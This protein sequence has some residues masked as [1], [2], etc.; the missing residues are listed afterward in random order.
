MT[1]IVCEGYDSCGANSADFIV[2]A[3][4]THSLSFIYL[5]VSC[6]PQ[7]K[8]RNSGFIFVVKK[9]HRA[10]QNFYI[11]VFGFHLFPF[12]SFSVSN[13]STIKVLTFI[14][15]FGMGIHVVEAQV[16]FNMSMT[17]E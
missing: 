17:S 10:P 11:L 16:T 7:R 4:D 13:I 6:P 1:T 8:R 5:Q 12:F 2:P 9:I 3:V 14:C 15:I